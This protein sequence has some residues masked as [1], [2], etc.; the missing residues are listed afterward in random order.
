MVQRLRVRGSIALVGALLA[1]AALAVEQPA[2]EAAPTVRVTTMVSGLSN[3]WD[4]TW[5]G[6]LMLY[7]LRAGQVWS[8]RGA[9]APRRVSIS[10]FPSI[11]AQSEGGLLGIVADPAASTNKRFYTCQSVRTS[12]GNPLDVR[13]LRWRLTSDTTAVSDGAPVVTGIPLSSGRHSGCRLRFGSDRRLYV[14]TGDAAVGTNPQNLGS[15]GGKVLRVNWNGSI[16]ADNPFYARGGNARYVW[17]YGHRN[18]QGL[19]LRPGTTELWSAEHGS[20]RD[21]E[22]NLSVRGGNYGWDP[23]PGYNEA[24][25]MTD[26]AK[27]PNARR[28]MWSS[29]F[30]TVATSGATFLQGAAW[31]E[32]QGALA[33]GLLKGQGIYLMRFDP[34][35]GTSRVARVVR[36]PG[37]QGF[38]RIRTV[39]LGPDGALWFTTSN[40]TNDRIVRVTPTATPPTVRARSLVSTTGVAAVRTGSEIWAFVRGSGDVVQYR[41][42]RDDGATW[43]AWA[44]A[45][46]TSTDPP[47]A[48]SSSLGRID[49]FTRNASHQVVHT[50]FTGGVRRGSAV[51]PGGV[52]AQHG[53][54][55][56]G[57]TLDVWGVAP[58][59]TGWRNH[60]DGARW[61]GWRQVGGI[62]TSGLYAS[63]NLTTKV[64]TVSGRGQLPVTYERTF[65]TTGA[66]T[67]GW[68]PRGDGMS[69]WSSRA[70]ADTTGGQARIAVT[71][72]PDRQ[73]VVQRNA[74]QIGVTAMYTSATD[75]VSRPNGTFV[76][77]GRCS[78]GTLCYY[79]GRPGGYVNRSL[80]GVVR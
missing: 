47:S 1:G 37:A 15:L 65:T 69:A 3:P 78:N 28:A 45:G 64:T 27:F 66:S 43:S 59:G 40:G 33:V 74:L 16:P 32:W 8:K 35:P 61:S 75:V 44:S 11:F 76:M 54:S 48:A 80:G 10:G 14:G 39:Q 41:R 13:V 72:G 6:G 67:S 24:T 20:D 46:I 53:S 73:A 34:T 79:D 70:M 26:T 63:A 2:A 17:N 19:A 5:V 12:A 77:F 7:D 50:W 55:V 49:L 4:L 9:N 18:V 36:L 60:H 38:G 31:G 56:G 57:G 58:N 22:M 21:D 52:I 62:F 30:P 29:G 71:T 25:P 51:L 42:S 68:V 23:V